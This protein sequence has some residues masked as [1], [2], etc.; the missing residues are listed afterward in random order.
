MQ[1]NPHTLQY[2][3]T[4]KTYSNFDEMFHVS[5]S[6]A[7]ILARII[8]NIGEYPTSLDILLSVTYEPA[9]YL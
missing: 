7:I 5:R 4:L 1:I 2:D 9:P 8:I 3:T 6:I